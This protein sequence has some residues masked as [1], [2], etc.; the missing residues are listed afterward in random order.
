MTLPEP[1]ANACNMELVLACFAWHFGQTLIVLV[2]HT[3]ADVA[4]LDS[5][6]FPLDV[7]L[8]SKDR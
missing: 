7:G 3:V 2:D 5:F 6:D 1:L 8:P 4:V